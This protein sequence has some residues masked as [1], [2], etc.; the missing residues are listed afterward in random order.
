MV[1]FWYFCVPV[2]GYVCVFCLFVSLRS[3]RCSLLVFFFRCLLLRFVSFCFLLAL[4]AGETELYVTLFVSLHFVCL[5]SF[6]FVLL[7]FASFA[8]LLLFSL[9]LVCFCSLF[10]VSVFFVFR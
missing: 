8:S 2:F 10:C 4:L 5:T 7:R 1:L 9:C 6:R 3:F